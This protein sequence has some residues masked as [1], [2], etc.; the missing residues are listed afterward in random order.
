MFRSCCSLVLTSE[1][2]L[3]LIA[4]QIWR[5][6]RRKHQAT[7]LVS[8]KKD[9]EK[10]KERKK[11]GEKSVLARNHFRWWRSTNLL[12]AERFLFLF[13]LFFFS[14]WLVLQI[15][16]CWAL[17]FLDWFLSLSSS[18]WIVANGRGRRELNPNN[19]VQRWRLKYGRGVVK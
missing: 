12:V 18:V 15:V 1:C 8:S 19:V 10:E 16:V 7:T 2:K 17:H 9:R 6:K 3:D 5:W 14:C 4:K 11:G 13:L